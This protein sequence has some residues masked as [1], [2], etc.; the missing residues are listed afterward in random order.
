MKTAARCSGLA[1]HMGQ[2]QSR[3]CRSFSASAE[4]Q[5]VYQML[6][7]HMASGILTSRPLHLSTDR[8][9]APPQD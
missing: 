9:T 2:R 1:D 5:K 7:T 3:G 8:A 6:G 4:A